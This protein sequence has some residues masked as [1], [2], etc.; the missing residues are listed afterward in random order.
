MTPY[1]IAHEL[2][3]DGIP[4]PR[5]GTW[6]RS[7]LYADPKRGG[8]GIVGNPLYRGEVVWNRS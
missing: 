3:T 7:A 8:V 5:G 1:S 6:A 4:G 2:N